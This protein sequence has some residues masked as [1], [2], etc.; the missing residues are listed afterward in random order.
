M[1]LKNVILEKQVNYPKMNEINPNKLINRIPHQWKK[2][3]LATFILGATIQNKTWAANF[4]IDTTIQGGL[5][6]QHSVYGQVLNIIMPI[7]LAS[8]IGFMI[9]LI[10]IIR[11]KIIGKKE[12]RKIKI[13]KGIKI[14]FIVSILLFLITVIGKI[15]LSRDLYY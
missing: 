1:E 7:Q 9:S 2:I 15:W 14:I 8:I 3:G 10:M 13:K 6:V 4:T 5:P 11:S 12:N